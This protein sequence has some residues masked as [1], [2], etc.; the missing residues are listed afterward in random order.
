MY[1]KINLKLL[2]AV[3]VVLL[4]VVVLTEL[5]DLRKGSRTFKQ[6]LVEV[7]AD[8]ITAIEVTAKAAAGKPVTLRKENDV[9]QV[10]ADGKKYNADQSVANSM[11]SQ[12]NDMKPK[13][14]VARNKDRWDEFEVTDSLGT[15]V[16]LMKG[17]EVLSD[18]F[19]GKFSFSQPQTMTTYV[20]LAD[21]NEIYGIDGMVGMSFN[22]NLDSFRD[23]TLLKSTSSNWNK[24]TFTYP[25]DS[26]FVLEKINDKWMI[27]GQP[28]D[29]ASVVKYFNSVA[30][31]NS[32]NFA[33]TSPVIQPT[34][35]L[36]IEGNNNM[37]T[38]EVTGYYSNA[39]N[40]ILGTSQNRGTYFNDPE[41]AE[42]LFIPASKLFQK[43][44]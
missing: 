4:A 6:D 24:L 14:V 1:R 7:N 12:L 38:V 33:E 39:E 28:A 8:E 17:D 26:S 21:E 35:R 13:S 29:S 10:E 34:H 18:V 20:R 30:R 37:E 44:D 15:R 41:T 31:Q 2:L 22:R 25:A 40:F 23:K 32:S 9:W 16:K 3:F 27:G 43:E 42:K 11:M 5:I 19:F 36:K